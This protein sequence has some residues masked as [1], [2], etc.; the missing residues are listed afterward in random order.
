MS[1]IALTTA[2]NEGGVNYAQPPASPAAQ[3]QHVIVVHQIAWCPKVTTWGPCVVVTMGLLSLAMAAACFLSAGNFGQWDDIYHLR[4]DQYTWWATKVSCPDMPNGHVSLRRDIPWD[5]VKTA[6]T[7][8]DDTRVC[9]SRTAS[10]G[11][12]KAADITW[13]W[14]LSL[15]LFLSVW[16]MT[17]V[18]VF[19]FFMRPT[20]LSDASLRRCG[21]RARDA[22]E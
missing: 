5:A 21:C 4:S 22:D 1:S 12:V 20:H 16:L 2:P 18:V 14:S 13:I 11:C 17:C 19:V 10:D 8:P 6:C 3:Q 7:L 15:A 9:Y